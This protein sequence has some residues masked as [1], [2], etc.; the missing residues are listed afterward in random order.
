MKWQFKAGGS[1]LHMDGEFD[2]ADIVEALETLADEIRAR[3]AAVP[4]K[5][6]FTTIEIKQAKP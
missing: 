3:C 2:A 4:I 6:D 1:I 5:P